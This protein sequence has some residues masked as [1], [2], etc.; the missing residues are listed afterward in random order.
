M[1]PLSNTFWTGYSP[2]GAGLETSYLLNKRECSNRARQGG[3]V[4]AIATT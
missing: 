3:A 1:L 2:K 4:G